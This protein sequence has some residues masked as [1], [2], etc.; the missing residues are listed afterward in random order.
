M[1]AIVHHVSWN[2]LSAPPPFTGL[3]WPVVWGPVGG[4]QVAPTAF[5]KVFGRQ[6]PKELLRT[7]RVR[8]LSSS[9]FW[10]RQVQSYNLILATNR[11][12]ASTLCRAGAEGVELFLDCGVPRMF[13]L[14]DPPEPC[15]PEELILFWAGRLESGKAL[16]LALRALGRVR[17]PVK[18]LVAGDGPRAKDWEEEVQSLGLGGKVEFLG[19]VPWEGMLGLFRRVHAFLFTSLRDSSGSVVLEAMAFGLPVIV[20]DHQGVGTFVP[21]DAGIKVP[22]TT[23]QATVE[24]IAQAIERLAQ[25]SGLRHRLALGAWRFAQ[26]ERW[27]RRAE[28][29]LRLYERLLE[30]PPQRSSGF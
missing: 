9:P 24:A 7:W 26:E 11:E 19:R 29:M 10:R 25:N 28:R 5:R 3:G 22:I 17:A 23:P 12:T 8:L 30:R 18:L 14:P 4:G 20:P 2:T 21:E 6:W 15:R 27:N 16:P 1:P 13:G